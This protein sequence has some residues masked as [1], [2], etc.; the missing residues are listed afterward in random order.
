MVLQV[1]VSK[2]FGLPATLVRSVAQAV[3]DD[4]MG[5]AMPA[6]VERVKTA[7]AQYN[8]RARPGKD[9]SLPTTAEKVEQ[10][11]PPSASATV[12]QPPPPPPPPRVSTPP[13]RDT[14]ADSSLRK[15]QQ[16]VCALTGRH[17]A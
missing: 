12:Q 14:S 8:K 10:Q 7:H 5:D 3:V 15:L 16:E 9:R 4:M 17:V 2:T 11:A 13:P 1:D 6:L